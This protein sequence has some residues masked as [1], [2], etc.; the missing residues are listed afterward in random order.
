MSKRFMDIEINFT[1]GTF[2]GAETD[3]KY[4]FKAGFPLFLIREAWS[5]GVSFEEEADGFGAGFGTRG[6]WSAIRDSSD[7]AINKM[8]EKALN[9]LFPK[10]TAS[11]TNTA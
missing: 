7:D 11:T 3:G 4:K 8:L 1:D 9:A 5:R 10:L 6:D 2:E